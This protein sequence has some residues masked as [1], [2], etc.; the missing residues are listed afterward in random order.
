VT[1]VRNLISEFI[2]LSEIAPPQYVIVS[3]SERVFGPASKEAC[4]ARAEGFINVEILEVL[5]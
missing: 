2:K 3:K 4:E 5:T 1:Q